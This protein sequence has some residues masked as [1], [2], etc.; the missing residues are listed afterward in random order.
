[1]NMPDPEHSEGEQPFLALGHVGPLSLAGDS[2]HPKAT[3][4]AD[5]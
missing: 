2:L 1:M 5:H 3:E 4:N